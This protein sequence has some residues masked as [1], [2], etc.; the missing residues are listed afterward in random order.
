MFFTVVL[1]GFCPFSSFP[2]APP[3]N[4]PNGKD[5]HSGARQQMSLESPQL[6]EQERLGQLSH[7]AEQLLTGPSDPLPNNNNKLPDELMMSV[8]RF[9]NKLSRLAD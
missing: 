8:G 1:K 2:A 7:T 6:A 5:K 3:L 4:N 9:P